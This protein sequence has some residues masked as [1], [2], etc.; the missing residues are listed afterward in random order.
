[1]R[2]SR[3]F[4]AGAAPRQASIAHRAGSPPPRAAAVAGPSRTFET[5][6]A[7][8]S[9]IS[10]IDTA[11]PEILV[12]SAEEIDE[13][14]ET[15]GDPHE[16]DQLLDSDAPQA[17]A[18]LARSQHSDTTPP[19][20]TA[21]AYLMDLESEQHYFPSA[22]AAYL[23]PVLLELACLRQDVRERDAAARQAEA[24]A[25][26]AHTESTPPLDTALS[27]LSNL[28]NEQHYSASA[29]ATYLKPVLQEL[30]RLRHAEREHDA[31]A[32]ETRRQGEAVRAAL[33][34][35]QEVSSAY[36]ARLAVAQAEVATL[37]DTAQ[38][39]EGRVTAGET[40]H[41]QLRALATRDAELLAQRTRELEA[42]QAS[43]GAAA[44]SAK[45]ANEELARLRDTAAADAWRIEENGKKVQA[46][47]RAAEVQNA[48]FLAAREEVERLK[49][50]AATAAERREAADDEIDCWR[51]AAAAS[52][53]RVA[54]LEAENARLKAVEDR[55]ERAEAAR[56]EARAQ[57]RAA[58]AEIGRL[59]VE[60][61]GLREEV[62]VADVLRV[63]FFSVRVY[64]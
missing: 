10:D 34:R 15:E 56:R 11:P 51:A 18:D 36:A 8:P 61:A 1:M 17:P 29:I 9:R 30:A 46:L 25:G 47:E 55:C 22:I 58:Q 14:D 38:L 26:L 19:L 32:A 63:G 62:A 13:L 5:A 49:G 2:L 6:V 20:D 60:N 50:D 21:L 52:G 64:A 53:E 59:R 33:A 42:L 28:G 3:V 24:E 23:K 44:A 4:Q 48:A 37:K 27:R 39:A 41:S 57:L 40:A 54:V 12:D 7:G 43:A 45:T 35:A 31:A 16:I